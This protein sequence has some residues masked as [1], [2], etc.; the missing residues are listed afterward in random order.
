[1]LLLVHLPLGD[2]GVQLRVV[3]IALDLL[4]NLMIGALFEFV[5]SPSTGISAPQ[6][7]GNPLPASVAVWYLRPVGPVLH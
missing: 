7:L 4:C 5:Q 6:S 1:M 2:R 3:L